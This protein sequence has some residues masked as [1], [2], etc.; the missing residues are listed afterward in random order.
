MNYNLSYGK[1]K[2]QGEISQMVIKT[3]GALNL[4]EA[5]L[6]RDCATVALECKWLSAT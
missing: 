1:N 5:T 6:Y 2:K 3:E 4:P